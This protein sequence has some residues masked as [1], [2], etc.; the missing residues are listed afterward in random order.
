[1]ALFQPSSWA[2]RATLTGL[3]GG[4]G[5]GMMSP[6][7]DEKIFIPSATTF[8]GG[9]PN[10]FIAN[11]GLSQDKGATWSLVDA[12]VPGEEAITGFHSAQM[13]DGRV[14]YIRCRVR[15]G[16]SF[17][18]T[19][20]EVP[21]GYVKLDYSF[22]GFTWSEGSTLGSWPHLP[23]TANNGQAQITHGVTFFFGPGSG[24]AGADADWCLTLTTVTSGQG[25]SLNIF[26]WFRSDD[27]GLTW[28]F[29]HD[30]ATLGAFPQ[31]AIVRGRTG[32]IL[33][34]NGAAI[35][36][37]DNN[38]LT[39]TGAGGAIP[40][41]RTN[42][43]PQAGDTWIVLHPGTGTGGGSA[44]VSC[45]NGANWTGITFGL[46]TLNVNWA[47]VRLGPSEAL[48]TISGGVGVG[49]QIWYTNNGGETWTSPG[50]DIRM[51]A[52]QAGNVFMGLC[53]DG[54]PIVVGVDGKT[55]M[56]G[57]RATGFIGTRTICPLAFA[58]LKKA[59]I[60]DNCGH[61]LLT[62]CD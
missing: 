22:D 21:A 2:Q 61:P 13:N 34:A 9:N 3:Y 27:F 52:N 19:N 12:A 41:P 31:T 60:P 45:D 7:L 47:A 29:H 32:R 39:W 4:P 18:A 37:S 20:N 43:M 62:R 17:F 33:T 50:S 36:Y 38:G 5:G 54:A 25:T 24:P 59:G 23:F 48:G 6:F 49:Q 14:V 57:D 1:M 55:F 46:G 44:G 42:F 10:W 51:N 35:W 40:A 11:S 16:R 28:S 58:G 8:T 56:S 26:K 15:F 53:N 30:E